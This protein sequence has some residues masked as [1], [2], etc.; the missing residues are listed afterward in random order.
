M[1]YRRAPVLRPGAM[2]GLGARAALCESVRVT[3]G[4]GV[5][6]TGA[7]VERTIAPGEPARTVLLD[8]DGTRVL[9]GGRGHP[10]GALVV[11]DRHGVPRLVLLV[12]DWAP[13]GHADDTT[14]LRTSGVH[15]FC[16]AL[17]LPLEPAAPGEWAAAD[18]RRA[19]HRPGAPARWPGR[20]S[21]PLARTAV[22]LT[23]VVLLGAGTAPGSR[24]NALI[25][26]GSGGVLAL[27]AAILALLVGVPSLLGQV[28]LLRAEAAGPAD[29]TFAGRG[30]VVP[31]RPDIPVPR[32]VLQHQLRVRPDVLVLRR[33]G[34]YVV[35]PGP[36]E[37]GVTQAVLEPAAIRLRAADG[38]L[39]S[40]LSAELWCPTQQSRAAVRAQL[41]A[42]GLEVLDSP[43][44]AASMLDLD[45]LGVDGSYA[46]R[47]ERPANRGELDIWSTEW[48]AAATFFAAIGCYAPID[49]GA[50]WQLLPAAGL[51]AAC[52]LLA[53]VLGALELRRVRRLRAGRMLADARAEALTAL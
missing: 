17:G 3:A 27:T 20:A 23:A 35:L 21:L 53:V 22:L 18:L 48:A 44:D 11:V 4:G 43:I 12:L 15:A 45:E 34:R 28:A 51:G 46:A 49:D 38:L 25:G 42:A 32:M 7:G 39:Y 10:G 5:Q 1:S 16:G 19:L 33:Y 30:E 26:E 8:Q 41:T 14:L 37:G 50:D 9:L 40:S 36:A 52:A 47:A 13:P 24:L 6:L 29:R 2:G 31:P